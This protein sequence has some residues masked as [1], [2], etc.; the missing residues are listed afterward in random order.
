[1]QLQE[2]AQKNL[3]DE[4]LSIDEQIVRFVGIVDINEHTLSSKTQKS[5][6]SLLTEKEDEEFAMDLASAQKIRDKYNNQLG[7]TLSVHIKRE[8]LHQLVF[9]LETLIIYVTYEPITDQYVLGSIVK[10]IELT[11]KDVLGVA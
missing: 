1:M 11:I 5:K 7:K 2:A 4:I 3:L 6:V 9:F 10:K 8:N